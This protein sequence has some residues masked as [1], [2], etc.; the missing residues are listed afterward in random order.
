[1]KELRVKNKINKINQASA[2]SAEMPWL[3]ADESLVHLGSRLTF[4]IVFYFIYYLVN[5][6]FIVL[7]YVKSPGLTWAPACDEVII[8]R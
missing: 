4:I 2:L 5:Y 1:M 8:S 6:F 3:E 7:F